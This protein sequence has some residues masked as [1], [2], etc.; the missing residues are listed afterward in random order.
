MLLALLSG[1]RCQTM[2]L[3]SVDSVVLKHDS[4]VFTIHKLLKTSWPGKH[5]L[6]YLTFTGY[7][8]DNSLCPI[9]YLAEYVKWTSQLRKGSDHLFLRFYW[10]TE[11]GRIQQPLGNSTRNPL[12]QQ[13]KLLV[14]F[15]RKISIHRLA[16]ATRGAYARGSFVMFLETILNET[17]LIS[18]FTANQF[19]VPH[20]AF[21]GY[22]LV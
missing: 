17:V 18:Y 11:A 3:L 4:C 1:Q 22:C 20:I 10:D 13:E 16:I 14:S 5:F 12:S 19:T 7:S 8:P 21:V 6:S 15:C 2:H 9:V